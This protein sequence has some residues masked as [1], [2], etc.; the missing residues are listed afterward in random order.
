MDR[1]AHDDY[2]ALHS[3]YSTRATQLAGTTHPLPERL[4]PKGVN[5]ALES[6][7]WKADSTY[8]AANGGDN[9]YDG[10]LTAGSKWTSNGNPPPHWLALDLGRVRRIDGFSLRMAGIAGER[11]DFAFKNYKIE[12]GDSID[13]PWITEFE[14]NN[15]PQFSNVHSIFDSPKPI[16]YVRIYITNSGIDNYCRLP[17]LEVYEALATGTGGWYHYY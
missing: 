3:V 4:T 14:V 15:S 13:G 8:D 16:R 17:E 12:S 11:F 7:E 6:T 9:A 5:V 1:Y 10:I 2:N